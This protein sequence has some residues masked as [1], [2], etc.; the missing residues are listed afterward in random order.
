[1]CLAAENLVHGP[2]KS[3]RGIIQPKAQHFKLKLA[4][5]RHHRSFWLVFISDPDL[6]IATLEKQ[7]RKDSATMQLIRQI[8][9]PGE[10]VLISH[11][12]FIQRMVINAHAQ[13]PTFFCTNKTGAPYGDTLGSMSPFINAS[14]TCL[15][16]SSSD[17]TM[18]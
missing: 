7:G 8:I 11:R 15:C 14:S 5:W 1:M 3:S 2:L 6:V 9:N 16:T 18:N 13:G 12:Y 4:H 17:L 10:W